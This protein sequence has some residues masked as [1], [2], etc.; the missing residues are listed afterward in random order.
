[1]KTQKNSPLLIGEALK[2][3]PPHGRCLVTDAGKAQ[4]IRQ[5]ID[6]TT[7]R[8]Q[9][10]WYIGFGTEN[11]QVKAVM[12][13]T[14]IVPEQLQPPCSQIANYAIK[15]GYTDIFVVRTH[16][17]Q[18]PINPQL[19]DFLLHEALTLCRYAGFKLSDYIVL[20]PNSHY[21]HNIR[22]TYVEQWKREVA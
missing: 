10:L 2:I 11:N 16:Y 1:M 6:E 21:A 14:S 18:Q 5:M 19:E 8:Q 13:F 9:P 17:H 7:A 3:Q 15:N 4:L 12:C 22:H 20:Q